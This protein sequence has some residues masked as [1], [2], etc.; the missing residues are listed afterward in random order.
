M[1]TLDAIE[2]AELCR[3]TGGARVPKVVIEEAVQI[4]KKAMPKKVVEEAQRVLS[5]VLHHPEGSVSDGWGPGIFKYHGPD[6]ATTYFRTLP[7][8]ESTTVW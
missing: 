5:P 6:G 2:P 4:V 1:R 7:N 3:I 8:G